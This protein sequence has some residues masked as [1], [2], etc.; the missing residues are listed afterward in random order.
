MQN[1]GTK[2]FRGDSLQDA[3]LIQDT[4]Q[5]RKREERISLIKFLLTN[6]YYSSDLINGGDPYL[7]Q[8]THLINPVLLH[9]SGKYPQFADTTHFISFSSKAEIAKHYG[10][11]GGKISTDAVSFGTNIG[12]TS[13]SAAELHKIEYLL[14]TIDIS[15]RRRVNQYD[16][17]FLMPDE[18][19]LLIDSV[20]FLTSHDRDV[21]NSLKPIYFQALRNAT[22]DEEWLVLPS[23]EHKERNMPPSY[24]A[25]IDSKLLTIEPFESPNFRRLDRECSFIKL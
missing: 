23:K 1:H 13:I 5:R 10:T 4:G 21:D 19:M 18:S 16:G 15:T 2:I 24:S 7:L 3:K 14:I 25:L 17:V 8:K 12:G 11:A 9:I 6:G 20:R 22:T